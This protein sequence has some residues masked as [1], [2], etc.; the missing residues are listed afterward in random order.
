MWQCQ[1]SGLLKT[2]RGYTPIFH[3][4]GQILALISFKFQLWAI[5]SRMSPPESNETLAELNGHEEPGY[6][7]EHFHIETPRESSKTEGE[8]DDDCHPSKPK[9]AEEQHEGKRD[10]EDNEVGDEG[11]DEG[12]DDGDEDESDDD[13]DEEP[14]LKYERIGGSLGDLFKKDSGSALTIVNKIMVWS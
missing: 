6:K 11:E 5:P 12:E 3:Q 13:D 10:N 4:I 7:Q 2:K 9:Y 1:E 8:Q 14:A